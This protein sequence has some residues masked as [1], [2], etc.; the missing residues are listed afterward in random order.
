M[1]H[2]PEIDVLG[3]ADKL[4]SEDV[5]VLLDV[6]ELWELDR[7]SLQDMRLKVIPTSLMTQQRG[8]SVAEL[9]RD[10][11]ILVLCHHGIRS[12]NVTRW[13]ISQGWQKVFS[14][15]GGIHQYALQVDRSV[16]IYK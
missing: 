13:L 16:G 14:V 1:K 8:L 5:F 12:A 7:A 10:L 3:L 4:K 6:R 2:V 15:R 9:P 11:E